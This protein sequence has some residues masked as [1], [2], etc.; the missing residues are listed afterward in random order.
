MKNP[1]QKHL[2]TIF[3]PLALSLGLSQIAKA[4][5]QETKHLQHEKKIVKHSAEVKPV[6][7]DRI[8][9]P[10]LQDKKI[11][12]GALTITLGG[13]A[14]GEG[15][16]RSRNEQTDI[17]STFSGIPLKNSPLAYMHE[18]RL[19]A[20]QSRFSILVEGEV[21]PCMLLSAYGEFDFLGNGTANSNESNS[22]NSRIRN[23]YVSLDQR[24][25]GW[26]L[27]AG[28]NW[29]LVTTNTK[30]I[31]P[32][33][34][35]LPPTIDAQFVV[36][37]LWKRQPQFRLTKEFGSTVWAAIS[38]ENP[39]TTFGGTPCGTILPDGALNQTCTAPGTHTLPSTTN[40][41]LNHIPDFIGKLAFEP[42][43][44]NHKV[45]V[46]GFGLYRNL[47]NRVHYLNNVNKNKSTTAWGV[48]SGLVVEVLPKLLDFQGSVMYGHGVGSYATGLLP[49]AT[50]AS[51]G[52]LAAIPEITFMLGTTLH[53][54]PTLDLY[55]FGGSE[56]E[57]A[58]YFQSG[59]NFFGYGVPDANNSGCNTEFGICAGTTKQ[60]WQVTAGLWDKLYKGAYGEL[61]AGV[62]YSYT[63]RTLFSGTNGGRTAPVSAHTD[64]NMVFASL[65]Y[66]P[67]V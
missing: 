56:K 22:F 49:D 65:R 62:Q 20:R 9:K 44:Q 28:Q 21:N 16:W 37:T 48:G 14:A 47:Y 30:G 31:T 29:S 5:D 59:S 38:V 61:R 55:L 35:I 40:F 19:T 6:Y 57:H 53:A 34:E 58:K 12:F 42:I 51:D 67:F 36:G 4:E 39:Q 54:T 2:S 27:L 32:R 15:L 41:S 66:Y 25:Q 64:D 50:L 60:L 18:L 8:E 43:I 26:H 63:K 7:K 23:L 1:I 52:S 45:H 33:N 46:E 13:F 11:H 3:V 24:D 17:G 10:V